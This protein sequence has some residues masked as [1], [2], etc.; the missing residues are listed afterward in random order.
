[1]AGFAGAI[2][3]G[4]LGRLRREPR[5]SHAVL[6]GWGTILLGMTRPYE[7]LILCGLAAVYLAFQTRSWQVWLPAGAVVLLGAAGMFVYNQRVTGEWSKLPY[8]LYQERYG[9]PQRLYFQPPV[10]APAGVQRHKDLADN[11]EWQREAHEQGRGVGKYFARTGEKLVAFWRFLVQPLFTIP[12]LLLPLVWRRD[13][14]LR[15][16]AI[17]VGAVLLASSFYPFFFPHYAAPVTAAVL[18]LIV[19]G[20]RKLKTLARS[21][22]RPFGAPLARSLALCLPLLALVPT[23]SDLMLPPAYLGRTLRSRVTDALSQEPGRH[24]V[25]VRYGP[26]HLFHKGWVYNGADIDAAPVVWARELDPAANR[27]AIRYYTNRTVWLFEPD[28]R[29][30]RL[31][32]FVP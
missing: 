10:E 22:G 3:F 4:A 31:R 32:P 7:G 26:D 23:G 9:V 19:A 12:L 15:F 8:L 17:A 24:L 25:F 5:V 14:E 20:L 2:V 1:M 18:A 28:E 6:F 29:P 11:Y 16:L 30:A 21:D 27:E 13:R